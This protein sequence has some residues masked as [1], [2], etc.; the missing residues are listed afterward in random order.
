MRHVMAFV[1]TGFFLLGAHS[2]SSAV[3]FN[4]NNITGNTEETKKE[5]TEK[6]KELTETAKEKKS[7]VKEQGMMGD[8][9]AKGKEMMNQ[10]VDEVQSNV[11]GN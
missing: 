5:A 3:D 6:T 11:I 10:K 1:L 2:L 7:A 8:I 9:K 4:L